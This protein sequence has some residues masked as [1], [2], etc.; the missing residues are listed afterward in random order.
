MI[1][2]DKTNREIHVGDYIIYGHALG[3]SSSL[4]IGKVLAIKMRKKDWYSTVEDSF[5]ITVIGV[6][7]DPDYKDYQ[8][9]P[10]LCSTCG[11][12]LFPNRTLVIDKS[13]IPKNYIELL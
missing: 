4:R 3:R 11:H 6:N 8:N 1:P 2:F 13:Q 9:K 12:L 10:E 7:D 5:S